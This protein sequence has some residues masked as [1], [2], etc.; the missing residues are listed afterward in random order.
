MIIKELL[1]IISELNFWYK[2]QDA[3]IEREELNEILKMINRLKNQVNNVI[4]KCML[5][6]GCPHGF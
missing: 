1:D 2:E 6:N 5:V 4:K 3:G